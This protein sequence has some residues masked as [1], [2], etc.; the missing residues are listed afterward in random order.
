VQYAKFLVDLGQFDKAEELLNSLVKPSATRGEEAT[1]SESPSV[2]ELE[3]RMRI[4]IARNQFDAMIDQ[5]KTHPETAPSVEMLRSVATILQKGGQRGPARK[6]LEYVFGQ[7]I[8]E[9]RLNAA[10]ML[11]LAEI[12]IQDGDI[13]GALQIL[14]RLTLVVGQPFENLEP[15]ASLLSRTG[16]HAEAVEFLGQLMKAA[17]WDERIRLKL[18]QEQLASGVGVDAAQA[19]AVKVASDPQSTYMDR[20]DAASMLKGRGATSLGSAELDALA[21]GNVSFDFVDKPHFYA[22]RLR[23]AE[24]AGSADVKERLLRNALSD[25]PDRDAARVPLFTVLASAGKDQLAVS[26]IDPMLHG[27][28]LALVRADRYEEN[29]VEDEDAESSSPAEDSSS[30]EIQMESAL[31]SVTTAQKAYLAYAL[32]KSYQKLEDQQKALQYFRTAKS[33]EVSK[34]TK[35]EI[36]NS[37]AGVRAT[38]KRMANND[39]RMPIAHVELEQGRVVRPRLVEVAKAPPKS[40]PAS[41]KAPKGGAQ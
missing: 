20:E 37:I 38:I 4:A 41:S 34:V 26:V 13:A 32:G 19:E 7:E 17:P 6:I 9:H 31:E 39:Q 8:A 36:D 16:H 15:A 23:A 12:R 21:G 1:E 33:L 30:A 18:A 27:N 10:N 40:P 29:A 25:T 24:K 14:H 2:Q 28:F 5:Y 35:A 3:A 11:G 22:A